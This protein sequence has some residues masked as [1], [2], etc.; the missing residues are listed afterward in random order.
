MNSASYSP[1]YFQEDIFLTDYQSVALAIFEIYQPKTLV[2][3]GCGPGYLSREFAKLGVKV[4]AVDGFSNPD[5]A[6]LSVEFYRLDLNDP[7]AINEL[8]INRKFDL[9][10]SLEVAEHLQPEA[11]PNLISWLTKLAPVVVF[12]AA[13]PS[14]GGLGHINLRQRDYWHSLFTRHEFLAA[15]RIRERLRAIPSVASWY[16]YNILDYVHCNH[17]QSPKVDEA[18]H[19]LIASESAAASAYYQEGNKLLVAE[20]RLRYLPVRWYLMFRQ[21]MKKLFKKSL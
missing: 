15:D 11:S 3:F 16:R 2:D 7:I 10:L 12:S 9:A 17:P 13:V 20:A 1:E 4:T 21:F 6:N 14:Q 5:F 18:L 8:L 19:R